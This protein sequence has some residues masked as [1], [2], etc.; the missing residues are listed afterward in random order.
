MTSLPPDAKVPRVGLFGRLGAGN[1]GNDASLDVLLADL[2]TRHPSAA[3][4]FMCSGPDL[5]TRRYGLPAQHLH[6]FH[7]GV[8]R[9]TLPTL[10][11]IAAGAVID[12]WRTTAWVRRHDAVI[13]PGMGTLESTLQERPWQMPWSLFLLSL[14]ARLSGVKV[15]LACVGAS[16][17]PE[18]VNRWLMVTAARMAHYRSF[19]DVRS[20]DELARMGVRCAS[21]PVFPDLVLA[22]SRPT[23]PR[24]SGQL[25]VAV[26]VMAFHGS[27]AER[28][29]SAEV[30]TTYVEAM[31]RVVTALVDAGHRV[32][33]VIGDAEDHETALT[34][35]DRV[36]DHRAD[37]ARHVQY[38]PAVSYD[39]VMTQVATTDVVAAARYH[40]VVA[41]LAL[42]KP[43]IAIAYGNKHED[44]LAQMGVPD[45]FQPI[46]DLDADLLVAQLARLD[47]QRA[48]VSDVL[49]RHH[50]ANRAAVE[51][52]LDDLDAALLG[53]APA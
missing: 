37:A 53:P 40:N 52:Q 23:A 13:V 51:Q 2:R 33:L 3:V 50:D 10:G 47:R 26:G 36:H 21:D 44:L 18:P 49:R 9:R 32:R 15:A 11:R 46:R 14:S 6:W 7:S 25:T 12:A 45:H 19:R 20:R 43:T 24:S 31:V 4:D 48:E 5:I 22:L 38:E 17:I 39:E 27:N 35:L 29:R 8:R 1:I 28:G 41:G 30:H 16:H 42:H 34:I